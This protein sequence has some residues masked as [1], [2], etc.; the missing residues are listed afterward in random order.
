MYHWQNADTK[1]QYEISKL[2][3]FQLCQN[4]LRLSLFCCCILVRIVAFLTQN[5]FNPNLFLSF[6]YFWDPYDWGQPNLFR[7]QPITTK[8]ETPQIILFCELN[9]HIKFQLPSCILKNILFFSATFFFSNLFFAKCFLKN[10]F[11][12]FFFRK[13]FRQNY[14]F[15]KNFVFGKIFFSEIIFFYQKFF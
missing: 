4:P 14:L 7:A 5:F 12:A 2:R 6:I 9:L 3:Y 11:L 1:I 8:T 15:S 10:L 13:K